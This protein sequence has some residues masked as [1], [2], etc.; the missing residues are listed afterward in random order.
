M[1]SG[2]G[3]RSIPLFKSADS[4]LRA[5]SVAVVG[6]SERARW[7]A[8]IIGNLQRFGYPGRIWMVNPRQT[9][10]FGERC[11]PTLSALP[12]PPEHAMVIVPAPAVAAAL[13]DADAIGVRSATVYASRLGDGDDPESHQRGAELKALLSRSSLRV[14]G[15]NC[16]GAMS[17][18]ERL[19]A[20]PHADL[21]R[22]PPGQTGIAFQSGGILMYF[23]QSA[24]DRGVRFSYGISTGNEIDLDLADYLD[25]LVTD[26]ETRVI[27]L[28]IEG[29]RRPAAF[30]AAAARALAAGKPILAIKTGQSQRS[31]DAAQS[32]TGAI[33]GDYAA[34]LAMCDRYGIVNCQ[35][36]DDLV[37]QTLAF[38]FQRRPK[39]RKAA[40]ISNSGGAVDLLFDLCEHEHT[41]L[42]QFSPATNAALLPLMQGGITPKNPLDVGL[43][44]DNET[45]AAWCR[46]VLADPDVDMLAYGMQPRTVAEFGDIA[47]FKRAFDTTDKPIIGFSRFVY[48]PTPEVAELQN[49][50]GLP[51]IHGLDATVRAM[52]AMTFHAERQGKAPASPKPAKA[53]RLTPANLDETLAS[54]GIAGPV[55]RQVA[56]APEAANA[57]EAIGYPVALKIRSADIL[58]KTE[59]GGV[60]LGLGS[61]KA[62]LD[63]ARQLRDN[64][65]AAT[66]DARIDGFLVQQM[67]T[68]IEAIVGARTDPLYGPLLLV[69]AGGILV[70][71]AN[72]VALKLLPVTPREI[73]GLVDRLA[74]VRLVAGYRGR[75]AA[76]RAALEKTIAGLAR[77][78]LD[79][80]ARIR[81]IEINPLML[82]PAGQGAIAVDVRVIWNEA[83]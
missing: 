14:S 16:M 45:S 15:P 61:R 3:T 27:V 59:A 49:A 13:A 8:Q 17:Y 58:H 31:A 51:I 68:G 76:D 83:G 67:V 6:A 53:S 5:A 28:F 81:D 33:A 79:H 7:P 10:V 32:H 46:T 62:V 39:G 20:Y 70:E 41:T 9:E 35:T 55:S 19:F 57:A 66:P 30:M 48:Q 47:P 25:F 71:L 2:A 23:M 21:G 40:F 74:L 29:I 78:Y 64:A 50:L 26:P 82:M 38:H 80:R 75:P 18:R 1:A 22:L 60:A 72:D 54:Y 73:T 37:Q 42:A 11:Y 65:K 34:Y 44:A 52:N 43:P 63:A 12:E 77:F 24:A 36:L 56:T 69:G 4:V